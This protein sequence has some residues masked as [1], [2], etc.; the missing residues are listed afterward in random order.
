M[1]DAYPTAADAAVSA[2]MRRNRRR[3]TGPE[4]AVRRVLH[5]AGA[6]Y[7]VD[8]RVVIEGASVR[9]DIVFQGAKVAV[10]I[11]GCFWHSCPEH[12]TSPRHNSGYWS[13]K[14]ERNRARDAR[15]TA[16]LTGA[17]WRPLRFWEHEDPAAVAAAVLREVRSS[18]G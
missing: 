15:V 6:R 16:A 7:R 4:L 17:G 1:A 2:R 12:G 13:A 10:F 9:P 18:T 3:D 8:H 14:L 11:D 5:R